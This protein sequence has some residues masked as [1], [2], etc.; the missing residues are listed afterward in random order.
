MCCAHLL[1]APTTLSSMRVKVECGPPLP[2]L[3]IWFVVPAVSTIAE[4]K[5]ALCADLP[6]LAHVSAD[7]L[8]LTLDG[9][10]LIDTSTIDVVRDGELLT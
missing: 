4:L 8:T 7:A 5:V 9:F 1:L 10:E 3:K 2:S 6:V